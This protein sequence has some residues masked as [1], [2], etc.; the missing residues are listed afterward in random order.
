PVYPANYFL[1]NVIAVAAT[2]STDGLAGFSD[3]GVRTVLVGAPGA[4]V[5]STVRNNG[6]ASFSGT[7]MAAPHVAGLAALI[8]AF[9]P[10]LDIYQI[11]NLIVTGGDNISPL[12]GKSVSGK[13]LNA[14]NSL[15]CSGSKVFG[16]VRP[17]ENASTG[18]LTIAALNIK[19]PQGA[20][21]PSVT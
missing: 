15:T 20:A 16:L 5:E 21:R 3:W 2:T 12:A 8:H 10:S 6:Y 4:S 14:G 17:L 11:R 13:R 9:D 19:C 7:S 18:K 1:P